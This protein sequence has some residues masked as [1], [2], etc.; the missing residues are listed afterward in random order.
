MKIIFIQAN[1][2]ISKIILWGICE[3]FVHLVI[4]LFRYIFDLGYFQPFVIQ[5]SVFLPWVILI[6]G[7]VRF[8][9]LVHLVC[10]QTG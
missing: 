1:S 2:S 5:S 6:D 10:L 8:D 3:G 9:R 4:Q 7:Q